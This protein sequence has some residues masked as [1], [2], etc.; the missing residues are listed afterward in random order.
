MGVCQSCVTE[1][2]PYLPVRKVEEID[3]DEDTKEN[4]RIVKEKEDKESS[5]VKKKSK[6]FFHRIFIIGDHQ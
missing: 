5:S 3:E 6:K 2:K 1:R 4:S